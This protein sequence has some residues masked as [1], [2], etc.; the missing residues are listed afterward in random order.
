LRE[1]LQITVLM[2]AVFIVGLAG[3]Y[4]M[5]GIPG[6]A[7][8]NINL[9]NMYVDDY[10]ADFFL[11]GTL[12]EQFRY[13]MDG[14]YLNRVFRPW[15]YPLSF[16]KLDSPY[17]EPSGFVPIPGALSYARNWRGDLLAM[18]ED[19]TVV[20]FPDE[21]RYT[22]VVNSLAE[23]DEA[24]CYN[25]S[26]FDAGPEE[27]GYIFKIHP[28]LEQD[29]QHIHWNL[30]LADTHLPYENSTIKVH[31][32]RGDLVQLF[33][34][35]KMATKKVGDTWVITGFCPQDEPLRVEM[36]LKARAVK[37]IDG[38]PRNV[39]DVKGKTLSANAD[40]NVSLD[41]AQENAP[42]P[43]TLGS[44]WVESYSADL[45][46]NGTL[47]ETF[48]YTIR[49]S[50]KYRMLY[51]NWKTPLSLEPLNEPYVEP[52][53]VLAPKGTIPYI[54]DD[55]FGARILAPNGTYYPSPSYE[56]W[57]IGKRIAYI[58]DNNEIGHYIMSPLFLTS[59]DAGY[60]SVVHPA[61]L[62]DDDHSY[63]RLNLTD[64]HLPYRHL[65]VTVHDP[66]EDITGLFTVPGM[67]V[68]RDGTDWVISGSSRQDQPLQIYLLLKSEAY[69]SMQG[70]VQPSK[71]VAA[72]FQREEASR[73]WSDLLATAYSIVMRLLVLL[74]PLILLL[75]YGR[76]G[77]ERFF[78]VPASLSYVPN[79]RKPWEVNLIFK[80][81]P[82]DFDKDGFYA[83]ILNLHRQNLVELLSDESMDLKIRLLKDTAET[84][85][86]YERSVS[87][88]LHKYADDGVFSY[89]SFERKIEILRNRAYNDSTSALDE[90]NKICCEM[91][92]LMAGPGEDFGREFF[93]NY[94]KATAMMAILPMALIAGTGGLCL[95]LADG[96]PQL[97]LGF[98]SSV[99][100]LA[101]SCLPALAAP[102]AFFGR[103]NADYYKE[104]L[105]W[106]AFRA[107]LSDFAMIQKYIPED[108][109][110][111]KDWL[112]YGTALG[113]GKNVVKS[114]D[115]LKIPAIPEVHAVTF[116]PAHFGRAY[117][118]SAEHVITKSEIAARERMSSGGSWGGSH[119]HSGGG[120]GFGGGGHGGGGGGG[121]HGGG[122]GGAR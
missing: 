99:V 65:A 81:D 74:A 49:E 8:E 20:A 22:P 93:T 75:V 115:R 119:S 60:K 80:G 19:G 94:G 40:Y 103:W 25:P 122:G 105:E 114:M 44:I 4:L 77:K 117:S 107:F 97:N 113:V 51:R 101:Q 88:F 54:K 31:D 61:I 92:D 36:L 26:Y 50:G 6:L 91:T 69:L 5:G 18:D 39:S 29:E 76:F 71:D 79:K 1:K 35:P 30:L 109:S 47:K 96:Y 100:F 106:D 2:A 78:T 68:K 59:L 15:T 48:L 63:I 55:I 56:L 118:R 14:S 85:D 11:N 67:D 3:L 23:W 12:N 33:T 112:I 89:N 64:A 72:Q 83:T 32:S 42:L 41:S 52:V 7:R 108:I 46:L 45:Y 37:F 10:R 16:Q 53:R 95:I 111:W 98:Y 104:K 87:N 116:A 17:V 38:F 70:F 9:G 84:E 21:F 102:R 82:F 120:G 34:Q 27:I 62:S 73:S 24:G 110:I 58:S 86:D 13:K 28:P 90:L 57:P 43:G 66:E 121:G